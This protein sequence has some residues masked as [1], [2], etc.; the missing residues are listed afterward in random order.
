[1]IQVLYLPGLVHCDEGWDHTLPQRVLVMPQSVRL[2]CWVRGYK[3]LNTH[4]DCQKDFLTFI[5][6]DLRKLFS[7]GLSHTYSLIMFTLMKHQLK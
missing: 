3:E 7:Y 6:F 4:I 1:M 5:L 2:H